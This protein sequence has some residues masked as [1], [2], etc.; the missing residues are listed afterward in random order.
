ME[1]PASQ[2]AI[3]EPHC[4]SCDGLVTENDPACLNCGYSFE[5]ASRLLPYEAPELRKFIDFEGHLT[6]ED[7]KTGQRALEKLRAHF[8]Q[9]TVCTCV[10]IVPEG[11]SIS[12]F[13]FWLFNQSVPNGP[14]LVERRLHS[15]LLN[16]DPDR[17]EAA[18]TVGYGL[19]PFVDDAALEQC[20]AKIQKPLAAENYGK[21]ITKLCTALRPILTRGLEQASG[22]IAEHLA[23]KKRQQHGERQLAV[24]NGTA[25]SKPETPKPHDANV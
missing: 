5:F 17:C 14:R 19:D 12:E 10:A 7:I 25:R 11:V 13:G 24:P 1:L 22:A 15:I 9:I 3:A 18:L 20:L 16:V 8:P 6:R 21:A 2:I 4:P 23:G